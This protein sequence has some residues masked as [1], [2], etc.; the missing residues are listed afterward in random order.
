[1]DNF[2]CNGCGLCCRRL[3]R[4]PPLAAFDRG[5]GTCIHLVE[6]HC[7]IYDDRPLVCRVDAMYETFFKEAYNRM[8]FYTENLKACRSF[9][10]EAGLPES[11]RVKIPIS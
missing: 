9:Q 6:N 3:D 2:P 1:M 11:Q 4:M 7:S 10:E 5:D 8:L